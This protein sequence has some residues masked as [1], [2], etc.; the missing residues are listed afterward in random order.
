M[1]YNA[2][3]IKT[4]YVTLVKLLTKCKNIVKEI[5]LLIILW[6]F[7]KKREKRNSILRNGSSKNQTIKGTIENN[8]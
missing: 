8:K 6:V 5:Q 7:R 4:R 1:C 2:R 3:K